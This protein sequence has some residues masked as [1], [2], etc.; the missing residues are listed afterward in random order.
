MFHR[1]SDLNF[2]GHPFGEVVFE[3]NIARKALIP[4]IVAPILAPKK[5]FHSSGG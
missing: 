4:T 3:H 5:N 1:F 2:P